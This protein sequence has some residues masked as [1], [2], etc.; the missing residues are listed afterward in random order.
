MNQVIFQS[1]QKAKKIYYDDLHEH[2]VE[3]LRN[4]DWFL[5]EHNPHTSDLEKVVKRL[6]SEKPWLIKK[7]ELY[8][9]QF[10]KIEGDTCVYKCSS[11]F[12]DFCIKYKC[13]PDD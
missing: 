11:I 12:Y 9:R 1:E 6:K 13:F 10:N 4:I 7:G 8:V 2:M 3:I 5:K